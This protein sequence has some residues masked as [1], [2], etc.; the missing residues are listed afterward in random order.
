MG[1]QH[2]QGR[3]GLYLEE[4]F[5]NYRTS[6][7][8]IIPKIL[9]EILVRRA[10]ASPGHTVEWVHGRQSQLVCDSPDVEL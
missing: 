9:N 7:Q 4:S 8:P 2:G 3:G 6:D 10:R 5:F 1:A